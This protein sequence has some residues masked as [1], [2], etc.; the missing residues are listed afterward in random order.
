MRPLHVLHMI[1][2]GDTGGAMTHL[3]PL[4]SAL[5]RTGCDVHLVCLGEGGLVE[6]AERRGLSVAVLPMAGAR[7]PR[8]LSP[9]RRLLAAGPMGMEN[10]ARPAEPSPWDLAHT[11]APRRVAASVT[12]HPNAPRW[13]VVHT[14]GMRA[15]L[16]ARLVVK[17]M[18][19]RPCLFTTVH[20]DIQL[21]YSSAR[22]A[23][24]YQK[25]DR[26][27]ARGVDTVICVSD[28]LR[29]LLISRGYLAERLITIHSG[30]EIVT[31][32]PAPADPPLP[33][34]PVGPG[35]P[36]GGGPPDDWAPRRS[37]K[38]GPGRLRVG[39]VAR[40]VAVKDLDLMLEVA[41]LLRRTHPEVELVI[42]GDGPDRRRLEALAVDRG[43][44][45]VVR[46]TGRLAEVTRALR[47]L[48]VYIVTS[49]FEGG[50]SMAV[51]EAA[52][53]GLPVVATAAGGVAEAVVDGETGY[54]VPRGA[55]RNALA[56]ALAERAASLLDDPALR[57]RMGAAGAR[58]VHAR[59]TVEDTAA[60]TLRAY[61]RC[62]AG[63]D[64]LF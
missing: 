54:L 64:E 7:D 27:T 63:R 19:K 46:F 37:D 21:D 18:R 55:N 15:N 61:E 42:V 20:S 35:H 34:T 12:T 22:L 62:L 47:G 60:R 50:V 28:A 48:D 45:G 36:G 39:T 57:A 8:V 52:A 24:V 10:A 49:V 43:L 58:S 44:S 5:Q 53:L 59:F 9:L 16:P 32:A 30:L 41:A 1:G 25:I 56:A 14:H 23:Q 40:L 51:L 11:P 3:L 29:F 4:L 17:S 6:E 38:Q 13:D 2:G 26:L 31:P 33:A